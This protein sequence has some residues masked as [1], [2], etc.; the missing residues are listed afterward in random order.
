MVLLPFLEVPLISLSRFVTCKF[1]YNEVSFMIVKLLQQF[2]TIELAQDAAPETIPPA[3]YT[4][5]PIHNGKEKVWL[6]SH[7]T[8]YA[9]VSF[10]FIH[11][12]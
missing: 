11:F 7:L 8:M 12:I 4:D 5:C 6:K 3:G 2:S 1:A 10:S 9:H